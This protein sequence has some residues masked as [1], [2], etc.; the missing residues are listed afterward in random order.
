MSIFRTKSIELLKQEA[1]KHSLRKSLTAIDIIMLGIGVIIGTGI[2]VL[3]GVAAAKYAGPG[4]MLSFVLAGITCAFVC[5][6][7]SELAS[8]VP[9]AGSAYTYTYTSL[10]EF[11]AWL[12]GWNLILEYSVGASAVA[13]GWSAY[14]VGILKTAGIEVPKALTAVPADGGIVNLP[15]VLITLFLTF[16]LVKGVR[17]SANANRILVAIKLAAIFLF[18]FLAGPKVN[19]ANWEPFLPYG[20]AGVSAGAAF[21][22]FAYLGVDSIATAAEETH[23]PS[24]DMP[25]GIIGSL[26]VCTVL[27]ITVTAIMTGVVPYSQLNTAEPVS[28][29]LRSIGYNFGSALVGTGAIAGLSTV[30][31]VMIYAQTRAFFAMSRDGLIPSKVCKVHPKYGTPHIITII[32][33]VAVA[34]ISGFTPIHVVAEMCSIGTLFA[35]IIAMIGVMVL[36]KTKSDAERPFRCPSL[37]FVAVCAILFCLYIMINLA[38]GTWIRFVVWSLIGIAIYFLYGRSHSALNKDS[39]QSDTKDK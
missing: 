15:A 36:R 14:T 11:I 21:I 10:G 17:E 37:T 2:F 27:Y 6:A 38:T 1:S 29:V 32:V 19:A 12:V 31:L 30:L 34:L 9:I 24:R 22:F 23:N 13:G 3:T 7:Y 8:M 4:L 39:E 20:W 5:L 35:F 26:A 18:I 25:I 33:G 16:L 28:Y